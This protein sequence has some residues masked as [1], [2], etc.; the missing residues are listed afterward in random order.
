MSKIIQIS[1][2]QILCFGGFNSK[3]ICIREY[4]EAAAEKGAQIESDTLMNEKKLYFFVVLDLY[5]NYKR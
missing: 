5:L 1:I 3:Y 2:N 4:K